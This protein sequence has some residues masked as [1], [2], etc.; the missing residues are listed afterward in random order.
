MRWVVFVQDAHDHVRVAACRS[1]VE[2]AAEAVACV[3]SC[4]KLVCI[5]TIDLVSQ[6]YKIS[7]ELL[8][9]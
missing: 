7:R 5:H 9:T 2:V 8:E 3:V 4:R 1:V 6:M